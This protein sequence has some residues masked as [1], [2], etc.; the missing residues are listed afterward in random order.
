MVMVVDGKERHK[1][2]N[3]DE[4]PFYVNN[5]GPFS[6]PTETYEFYTLPFCKPTSNE[7]E[8]KK[9]KLGEIIQGDSAVLSDYKFPFRIN[10]AEKK[11]CTYS[12]EKNEIKKFKDAIDEYYYAEMIY[13]DLPIFSFIGS[14]D[15][16]DQA[17]PKYYLY[18]HIPFDIEYNNDQIIKIS[19][20]TESIRVTE[21]VDGVEDLELTL[22]Y[23]ASWTPTDTPFSERM[24]LYEEFFP[25]ELEIHWLSIMNS[26]F[27]VILLTGFLAIIM[28]KTLKN[29]YSRY[30]KSDEEE[31][32][33][34][35]EDYGWKLI[36][37]EVFRFPPHKNLFSAFYGVGW[38]FITIVSG[39]LILSLFGIFY[40][41]NGG[42]MYTA[43]IV[44][45]ALTSVISGYQSG[46]MYKNMGG[47]KWAWNII[48][49]ATLFTVP[50]LIV[51]FFSNTVAVTW[52]STVALP[53]LTIIEV[54]TIWIFIG[55]PL[56]V[57]GGIA[58]RRLSGP[59]EVP[60]RTKNFHR[61][62]PPVPWYRRLPVQ[63]TMAGFLPFSAIYIELFYI[64]NS[65]WGHSSYTL[66]GILCLVFII[67]I[68][69][70]ACI[71]V[72]LTYFQL[73]QEDYRWWWSSFIN[74]G[75]HMYGFLQSTF[76]FAYMLMVC[77]FFF[78]LL[79]T[80]GFF[81]S[82]IFEDYTTTQPPPP[83]PPTSSIY[84]QTPPPPPPHDDPYMD[85]RRSYDPSRPS[86]YSPLRTGGG[87]YGSHPPPPP[88][89]SHHHYDD[90]YRG[91]DYNSGGGG[92]GGDHNGGSRY[93]D[94]Y[95]GGDGGR[96]GPPSSSYGGDHNSRYGGSGRYDNNNN[97]RYDR[98]Y[99]DNNGRQGGY[100][101]HSRSSSS[102]DS[103]YGG[104][105]SR[106]DY[107]SRGPVGDYPPPPHYHR[108][109]PNNY[110]GGGRGDYFD[111]GGR[112]G[113]GRGGND[114]YNNNYHP[115][116]RFSRP[117]REIPKVDPAEKEKSK[118]IFVGNLPYHY[119]KEELTNLFGKFGPLANI[120]IG[121]DRKTGRSKGYAFVEFENKSDAN[122]AYH[123]YT[124]SDVDGRKLRLDWDVGI[125]LKKGGQSGSGS[126]Y[127]SD[128][129]DS[130]SSKSEHIIPPPSTSDF[131]SSGS[132]YVNYSLP[133]STN[134]S[135]SNINSNESSDKQHS[136]LIDN[137]QQ[138][139]QQQ[140]QD[141]L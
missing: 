22:T 99:G 68:I 126:G 130:S 30:S 70:T 65:V 105:D 125:E 40:P 77:Y 51:A 53:I 62:I 90:Y 60:C 114:R 4:I 137:A 129:L 43:C 75:S 66:F 83:P 38:Q 115:Y 89:P 134:N 110:N 76:Y 131:S 87:P 8:Y 19:I 88:P 54:L 97:N 71:T 35:Q 100:D 1:Y 136:S 50:L 48:L 80:V 41:N 32:T 52:H 58:G 85:H 82:L 29:D 123:E 11:L 111:K 25:K 98:G 6:N 112:Y 128:D 141:Q 135:E 2:K 3:N 16:T 56:T 55:F 79:G 86:S 42:T 18:T 5:V 15:T 140:P 9:S 91:G 64:F 24:K 124:T 17:K 116:N 104:G 21:L 47:T 45:Y 36:H 94:R 93:D 122:N 107:Y 92:R 33:D 69:V 117:R 67:L 34:Y 63:I 12:I 13:D 113:G 106:G 95:N 59:L 118:C 109:G 101:N 120:N 119:Q 61:E 84:Q 139:P 78:I 57:V 37:G 96:Q 7:F 23:S 20:K 46:K 108:G 27:L 127:K 14:V 103:R 44:L 39:I 49:T 10:F 28:M 31:D 72:T 74:G 73:S 132:G 133:D 121:T 138:Q 102:Y 81:S 26:F